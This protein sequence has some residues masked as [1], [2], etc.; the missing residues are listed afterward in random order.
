M[1]SL[2]ISHRMYKI[3]ASTK[4]DMLLV[5][6]PPDSTHSATRKIH[7]GT[8]HKLVANIDLLSKGVSE[9]AVVLSER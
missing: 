7:L 1:A 5:L 8:S 9:I 6:V 3:T 4:D 2:V